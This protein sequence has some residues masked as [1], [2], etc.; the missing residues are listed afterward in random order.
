MA[1]RLEAVR[2]RMLKFYFAIEPIFAPGLNNSQ[3]AYKEKLASCI[4]RP[5]EWLD[6][7]CGH[8]LL[9]EWMP[10]AAQKS[11]AIVRGAKRVVG[12]DLDFSSLRKHNTITQRV[13]GEVNRLP[14]PENTFDLITANMVV[15][16][17]ESP[18]SVL[19][20]IA[21]ILKP[22]GLF[23]F[24]TPNRLGYSSLVT[25]LIPPRLI[26]RV[27]EFLLARNPEDVYQTF[28]RLNSKR[29]VEAAARAAHLDVAEFTYLE[30]SAQARMLGPFV[31]FELLL[32]RLLRARGL[33][34]LRT[35]IIAALRKS[36]GNTSKFEI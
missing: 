25:H 33:A 27:A 15:E 12:L 32:I 28:Y 6:L 26:P 2:Q 16:H 34:P 20:E 29:A 36:G 23:L 11:A 22:G 30:S 13:C 24:H 17:I 4:A 9:P 10:G 7:G 1:S 8:Q 3:L 19:N 21:R 18:A 31:I 35:N 5:V 14:F